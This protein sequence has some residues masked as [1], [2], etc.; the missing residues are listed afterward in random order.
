MHVLF[1]V[2][3]NAVQQFRPSLPM[4]FSDAKRGKT[5]GHYIPFRHAPKAFFN[6]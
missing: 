2:F 6:P 1:S 5:H 4:F 3:K